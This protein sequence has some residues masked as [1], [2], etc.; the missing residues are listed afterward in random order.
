MIN[1]LALSTPGMDSGVYTIE[2]PSNKLR[3]DSFGVLQNVLTWSITML[4]II[5]TIVCVGLLV[6]G[7]IKWVT[8][9]GDKAGIESARNTIVYALIGLVIVFVSFAIIGLVGMIFGIKLI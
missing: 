5:A 3:G 1:K 9:G 7:G 8:S 6:Y 4:M 2:S